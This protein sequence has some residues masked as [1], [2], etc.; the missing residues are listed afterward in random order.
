MKLEDKV[1]FMYANEIKQG[2]IIEITQSKNGY[3]YRIEFL[4]K[5]FNP[6][7]VIIQLDDKKIFTTIYKLLENLEDEF[8]IKMGELSKHE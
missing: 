2:E 7:E 6:L 4:N 8:Y 3:I 5:L 1:F